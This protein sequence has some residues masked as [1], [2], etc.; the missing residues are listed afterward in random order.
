MSAA[1]GAPPPD[2]R[3]G[4][5]FAGV[6]AVTFCGLLAVGAVLPVLP[7]YVHGPLGAGNV[8]VG[9]VIGSYAVTGLLL[10][11]V[12]GRLADTAAASR[13]IVGSVLLASAAS[14]TCSRSAGRADRGAA[15]AR[16]RRG[17]GLHRRLGLDRRPRAARAAR[18]GD[19]AYGL[20]VWG[21]LSVGR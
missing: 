7:R 10:R 17:H 6:F 15:R 16:G 14:S 9:V 5:A 21:G 1:A 19:R 8:A 2:S 13:R 3:P 18:P 20:A 11:P 12:A 4:V